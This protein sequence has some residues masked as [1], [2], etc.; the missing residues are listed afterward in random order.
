VDDDSF[1]TERI[2]WLFDVQTYTVGPEGDIRPSSIAV[3]PNH[4]EIIRPDAESAV[5]VKVG[6]GKVYHNGAAVPPGETVSLAPHDRVGVGNDVYRF[7]WPG[8][9]PETEPMSAEEI[10]REFATASQTV[11]EADKKMFE[12]QSAAQAKDHQD[13]M[14][15]MEEAFQAKLV[16]MQEEMAKAAAEG[17]AATGGVTQQDIDKEKQAHEQM[18]AAKNA[19]FEENQKFSGVQRQL[20]DLMR[21]VPSVSK[22]CQML[23]RPMLGFE[24]KLSPGATPEEGPK[25]KIIV[26]NSDS[27]EAVLQDPWEFDDRFN[28]VQDEL[29]KVKQAIQ[30]GTDYM[31]P[32]AHDPLRLLF[33]NQ[34]KLGT[35]TYA[36]M[37]CSVL[38]ETEEP[39]VQVRSTVAPFNPVGSIEIMMTPIKSPEDTTPLGDDDLV[40][41]SSELIGKPWTY[42]LEIKGAQGLTITSDETYV[43]YMFNGDLFCTEVVTEPTK[44]P[45]W[46]YKHIHHVSEVTQEFLTFLDEGS[47]TYDIFVNPV[48]N[49]PS[50][51][52]GSSNSNIRKFLG[53]TPLNNATADGGAT[54]SPMGGT[55]VNSVASNATGTAESAQAQALEQQKAAAEQALAVEIAKV[56]ELEA[57]VAELEKKAAEMPEATPTNEPSVREKQLEAEVAQ[58]KDQVANAP[59]SSACTVL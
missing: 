16:A 31:V 55:S 12:E 22:M 15:K 1:R 39:I 33:D 44:T 36:L 21:K 25:P 46:E 53:G 49:E 42:M 6:E 26:R 37:E 45:K 30:F 13:E 11:S 51:K 14:T 54:I 5:Q 58:L 35:A 29:G 57:K 38:M 18:E 19:A 47:I 41:D 2:M 27:G 24:V 34:F 59:Q 32:E 10:I 48:V 50:T 4:C 17:G 9:D 56:K 52:V 43:Q 23:D 7:H 28:I 40:D 20:Q 8:K 3:V